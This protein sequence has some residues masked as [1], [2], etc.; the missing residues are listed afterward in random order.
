MPPD[1]LTIQRRPNVTNA[2]MILGL[3]GWMDGG[4]VSTGTVECLINKLGA[5]AFAEIDPEGFYIYNFPGSMEVS[6]LFRPHIKIEEGLIKSF[7]P[8]VST[9]F[10]D[11]QN[12]LVFFKGREPNLN[13]RLYAECLFSLAATVGASVIYFVGSVAGLV[14]HTRAPRLFGAVSDPSLKSTLQNCGVKPTDYEGPGS[15]VTFLMTQADRHGIGMATLV[16]EIP[17][18]VETTNLKCIELVARTLATLLSLSINL[19][20]LRTG[21]DELEHKLNE[22]VEERPELANHIRKLEEDYD[23]DVFDTRMGDLKDWLEQQGIRVD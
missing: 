8:P 10:C 14:P 9:F 1:A 3:S 12:K 22:A 11:E 2:T 23:N 17:A 7:D 19:D 13:W 4:D 6:A 5:S 21:S 16:A 18:Y 15:M 20:D